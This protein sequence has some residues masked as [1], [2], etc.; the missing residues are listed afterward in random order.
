MG[1]PASPAASSGPAV[2]VGAIHEP[3]RPVVE[4][5]AALVERTA[6]HDRHRPLGE[7]ALA[8]LK[9]GPR[10]F[11]HAAFVARCGGE[12]AGY[13]HLS[14]RETAHGWRLEAFTAPEF[15]G[16]GVATSLL[17]AVVE[18]VASHGGGRIH[19]WAYA[20]GPAHARLAERFRMR[21]VR[22][23]L[24]MSRD[25]PGP[26]APVPAGFRLRPF[27]PGDGEAWLAL[28]NRV[29]A[30]HPDG[31]GWTEADLA[32]HLAE[33]WFDPE[34]FLLAVGEPGPARGGDHEAR[35]VGYCWMKLE[36]DVG[37]V[38]FL[39]VD[40]PARGTGLAAGLC[41]AGLAWAR[42]RGARR[43]SLYA[44]EGNVPA[45]RLYRR[46]GFEVEHVD[47]CYQLDVPGRGVGAT[48]R[49]AGR[50]PGGR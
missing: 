13:A 12:L 42:G 20:P 38:Y 18:H 23:L 46:L 48:A 8:E 4:G 10:V 27:R 15:R 36:G 24:R 50:C 47:L 45:V 29:F 32:W 11:P 35:P 14:E 22:R 34:G 49:P 40:R 41:A 17:E 3:S 33:P 28:H 1:V 19:V 30:Q 43:A 44:D 6:R 26:A 31:G 37:W 16:R 7:H 5:L 25:L 21:L 2:R 9:Q 39:G